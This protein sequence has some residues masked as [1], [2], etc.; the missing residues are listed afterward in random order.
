MRVSAERG[1]LCCVT[2]T[3]YY[4][5]KSTAVCK[6][7]KKRNFSLGNL[8]VS[9]LNNKHCNIFYTFDSFI[10]SFNR[11]GSTRALKIASTNSLPSQT[12]WRSRRIFRPVY[13]SR[14]ESYKSLGVSRFNYYSNC[15]AIASFEIPAIDWHAGKWQLNG[16]ELVLRQRTHFWIVISIGNCNL[17]AI[18]LMTNALRHVQKV[19]PTCSNLRQIFVMHCRFIAICNSSRIT[20][21]LI[22]E[23]RC[24][25]YMSK[26]VFACKNSLPQTYRTKLDGINWH[27]MAANQ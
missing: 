6:I 12:G 3:H 13:L 10:K 22:D 2:I 21:Q 5:C 8:V 14:S 15:N 25:L 7:T 23:L 16:F 27:T 11:L 26:W 17:N 18:L 19:D 4:A 1:F 20:T 24:T 9:V